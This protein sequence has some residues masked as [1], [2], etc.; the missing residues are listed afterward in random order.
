MSEEL[1]VRL[2]DV[3]HTFGSRV[4]L[5]DL[6]L[7]VQPGGFIA[8]LG[9]SGSGKTTLLR[10]L[11]GLAGGTTT[12][13]VRTGTR[14]AV[15]FQDARLL[16]WRTALQ[17]VVL[18]Q[19]GADHE[20]AGRQAMAEVGLADRTDQW[21]RQLSGGQQ[22]RVALARALVRD[23][24][25]LLLDEP[26]SAL[27]ALTRTDAQEL[28]IDLWRRHRPA[29]V[30]VTHDVDEA[31]LLADR[32][33]VLSGGQVVHDERVAL[34]RPRRRDDPAVQSLA[35][36]LLSH[37]DDAP[38]I[39][40]TGAGAEAAGS[41]VHSK[42][43]SKWTR[44]G[45]L[46]GSLAATAG[47]VAFTRPSQ[48]RTSSFEVATGGDASRAHLTMAVQTDGV[49]S[50][51]RASRQLTN[52]PYQLSFS[53]F[54]FGPPVVEALGAARVD[55]GGVGSTPPIFGAASQTNFRVV[56]TR[57]FRNRTDNRLLV[58]KGSSITSVEQLAGHK[59]AVSKGS[60]AHG[61]L[62]ELLHRKQVPL[63]SVT[64][65]FLAPADAAA[66]FKTGRVDAFAVWEPFITQAENAGAKSIAGG[67]PDEQGLN[68]W[69]ASKSALQDADKVAALRDLLRRLQKAYAWGAAHQSAYA[70]AWTAEAKI[71]LS[72][73]RA[74]IPR[75]LS[76][77]TGVTAAHISSEQQLADRLR[78]DGVL[79]KAVRFQE[80]VARGLL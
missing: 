30:L 1:T 55:L 33:V 69:L 11:A 24:D 53:Q 80:I 45:V 79:P 41:P 70:A 52:L 50:L 21:P 20:Q 73:S 4:V 28:V 78:A 19:S 5:N 57:A 9:R 71:P 59:I 6:D 77:V 26:F 37:L 47:L 43:R 25:L 35:A 12:G 16:P 56:A 31:V 49:R 75:M 23:P 63:K 66:A 29:V 10:L 58:A 44:R 46:A 60:S 65:V 7:Q 34:S 67:P 42:A 40:D 39:V 38:G 8:V 18:G 13:Q 62:L 51:L 27:D 74:A 14:S 76:D 22:Q 17:N 68:F 36:E 61:F 64:L 72:V 15:V 54:S 32:V 3:R 2:H 48:A